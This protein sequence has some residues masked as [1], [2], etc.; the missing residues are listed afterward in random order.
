V[1]LAR[2]G[3]W[4]ETTLALAAAHTDVLTGRSWSGAVRVADLLDVLP[5]ALLVR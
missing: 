5:V 4:R 1:R 3:G 2:D